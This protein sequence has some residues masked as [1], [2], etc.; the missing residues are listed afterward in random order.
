MPAPPN[1]ENARNVHWRFCLGC[2]DRQRG[3]IC[4]LLAS[5]TYLIIF[6]GLSTINENFTV[7]CQ[8]YIFAVGTPVVNI[9]AS[10]RL[11]TCYYTLLPAPA[12]PARV[13]RVLRSV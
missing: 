8:P 7:S 1:W 13:T 10:P 9:A 12:R 11:V 3:I 6:R 2:H 4:N 5:F